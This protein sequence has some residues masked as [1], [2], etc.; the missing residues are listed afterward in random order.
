MRMPVPVQ[1]TE[2]DWTRCAAQ[3]KVLVDDHAMRLVFEQVAL[4][5]LVDAPQVAAILLFLPSR[6][7]EFLKQM[8]QM[9]LVRHGEYSSPQIYS[10]T[11]EGRRMR[12]TGIVQRWLR[13]KI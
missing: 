7:I 1:E 5:G 2:T 6:V 12:H 11:E 4:R 9:G 13:P 10:L 8:E 3:K